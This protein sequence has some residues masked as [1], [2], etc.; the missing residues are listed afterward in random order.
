MKIVKNNNNNNEEKHKIIN[1]DNFHF[2]ISSFQFH[3]LLNWWLLG[4]TERYITHLHTALIV[5]LHLA[6][7]N[8]ENAVKWNNSTLHKEKWK[9]REKQMEKWKWKMRWKCALAEKPIRTTHCANNPF[10][11]IRD[12]E[13]ESN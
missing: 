9:K 1:Y 6:S 10:G 11:E 3:L 2:I 4:Y 8:C 7:T 5:S 12:V 13:M